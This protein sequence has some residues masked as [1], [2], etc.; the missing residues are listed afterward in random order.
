MDRKR[1]K[2]KAKL[3][4]PTQTSRLSPMSISLEE[5]KT[6]KLMSQS[7]RAPSTQDLRKLPASIADLSSTTQFYNPSQSKIM[8]IRPPRNKQ[9]TQRTSSHIQ[10]T[11]NAVITFGN[12]SLQRCDDPSTK[13]RPIM[14]IVMTEEQQCLLDNLW[15]IQTMPQ[16]STLEEPKL[17][18]LINGKHS[19]DDEGNGTGLLLLQVFPPTRFLS[20]DDIVQ[21]YHHGMIDY[22][23]FRLNSETGRL[24]NRLGEKFVITTGNIA[25]HIF[26]PTIGC[27]IFAS[28]PHADS[29]TY[30]PSRKR[31]FIDHKAASSDYLEKLA[32]TTD[33][34]FANMP[35]LNTPQID[36][37]LISDVPPKLHTNTLEKFIKKHQQT[38]ELPDHFHWEQFRLLG[39]GHYIQ[40]YAKQ[41]WSMLLPFVGESDLLEL[42]H[43][44]D[45]EDEEDSDP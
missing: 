10:K 17:G 1:D 45:L 18:F 32:I 40:I 8:D 39:E 38:P 36:K 35:W 44:K 14:G 28:F 22:M 33:I 19:I 27:K 12:Y 4:Q 24:L 16:A 2:G 34:N 30:R 20:E 23:E 6:E 31:I 21:F 5:E 37:E 13:F 43:I 11:Q 29:H 26:P 41:N 9:F 25:T 42:K 7:I 3:I 15:H